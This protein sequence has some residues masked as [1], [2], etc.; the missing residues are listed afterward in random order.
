MNIA[1]LPVKPPPIV[2]AIHMA[3]SAAVP[4]A[5][6]PVPATAP[7]AAPMPMPIVTPPISCTA[8]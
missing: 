2:I 7:T 1:P 8:R 4:S 5:R 6:A 3:T